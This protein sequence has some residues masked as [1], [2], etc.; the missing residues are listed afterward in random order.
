MIQGANMASL[1]NDPSQEPN[2]RQSRRGAAGERASKLMVLVRIPAGRH[3]V[4]DTELRRPPRRLDL[5][6]T[7]HLLRAG[8]RAARCHLH[9]TIR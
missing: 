5:L 8:R 2:V 1:G 3:S 7:L 9:A 4:A 6:P